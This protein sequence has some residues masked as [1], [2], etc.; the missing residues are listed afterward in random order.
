MQARST[1]RE[2]ADHGARDRP[3]FKLLSEAQLAL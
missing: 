2:L 1:V 3:V